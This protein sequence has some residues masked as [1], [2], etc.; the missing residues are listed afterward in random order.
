MR[1]PDT[2]FPNAT[3]GG[4]RDADA[5]ETFELAVV[6]QA[7]QVAPL[8]ETMANAL[9]RV[10]FSP[11]EIADVR[12]ALREAIANAIRHGNGNDPSKCVRISYHARADEFVVVVQDDGMGFDPAQVLDPTLPGNLLRTTGRGIMLMRHFMTTVTFTDRGRRVTMSKARL[13]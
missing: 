2:E 4:R 11:R 9:G 12:I 7:D 3:A 8:L 1:N 10:D 13:S 6:R 5:Q